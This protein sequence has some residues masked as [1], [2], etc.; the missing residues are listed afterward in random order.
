MP[1][2]SQQSTPELK[3]LQNSPQGRKIIPI[4]PM[5][6]PRMTKGDRANYRPITQKY[7]RWVNA[8][9]S[10]KPEPN[11]QYLSLEFRIPMPK[12]WS[13]KKKAEM[14]LKPHT[15]TPDLDNLIKAFKDALLEQDSVVWRYGS[16][17]KVWD[18]EGSIIVKT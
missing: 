10:L 16:M 8:I 4:A 17:M 5:A 9:R 12:S 3:G 15:Q 18:Y 6:K 7:W 11:W 2:M 1:D 13:K 14:W